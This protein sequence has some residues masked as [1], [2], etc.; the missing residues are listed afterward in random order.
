MSARQTIASVLRP[1]EVAVR[2]VDHPKYGDLIAQ[3]IRFEY[4]GKPVCIEVAYEPDG[5]MS[6]I[7][8]SLNALGFPQSDLEYLADRFNK[9]FA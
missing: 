2:R 7:V 1:T 3:E 9:D 8:A 6:M 5:Y 4:E